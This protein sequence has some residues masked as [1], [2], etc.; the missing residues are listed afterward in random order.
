MTSMTQITSIFH[1]L[2]FFYDFN[3]LNFFYDFNDFMT[4]IFPDLKLFY[5]FNDF[6][7]VFSFV[8]GLFDDLL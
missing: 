1:D 7:N 6:I 3:D 8:N 5:D 4:S 2:N